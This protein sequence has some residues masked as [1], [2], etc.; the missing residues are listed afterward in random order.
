MKKAYADI[1]EGQVHYKTEGSGEPLLLL[2]QTPTS[3]DEYLAM[4]PV[5]ARSYRVV[6]LDTPGYGNSDNPPHEY[7]VTDYARSA[8]SFL[9]ALGIEKASIVGHH[10]GAAIATEVAA[11]YPERV[12]KLILSGC[13]SLDPQEWAKL[14]SDIGMP[15]GPTR[16]TEITDD[17]SFLLASWQNSKNTA[18]HLTPEARLKALINNLTTLLRPYNI[19]LAL[20]RYDIKSR[21]RLIKSPTLLTCGRED[22]L[23][24]L[25]EVTK[26]LVPRSKTRIIEGCGA[27]ICSEKPEEFARIIL[28]FLESPGG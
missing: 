1:P 15:S 18:P 26:Q 2:H 21:L 9:D 27:G 5:L 7:E 13:P 14:L 16:R 25:L 17:G 23:F 11:A 28:D 8:A 3:S 20:Q 4:I 19:I 22:M 10:T 24:G 6:A 12:D